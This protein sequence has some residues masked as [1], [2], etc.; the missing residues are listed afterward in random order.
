MQHLDGLLVT[1]YI[2]ELSS[3]EAVSTSVVKY[4]RLPQVDL[5]FYHTVHLQAA[6]VLCGGILD[7]HRCNWRQEQHI[8]G[9]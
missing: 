4:L 5:R 2:E 6:S 9:L 7:Q 8:S 3:L 1:Q